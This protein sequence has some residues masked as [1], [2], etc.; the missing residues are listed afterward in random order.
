MRKVL[1]IALLSAFLAACNN[2]A[3]PPPPP[4]PPTPTTITSFG[5]SPNPS[6]QNVGTLFNWTVAGTNLTCKVDV[7]NDGTFEYTIAPCTSASKQAHVYTG[8][9][10]FTAKLVVSGDD[11]T[12]ERTANITIIPPNV[13]P[14]ITTFR[15]VQGKSPFEVTFIFRIEDPDSIPMCTLDVD[16]DGKVDYEIQACGN[17]PEI[18]PGPARFFQGQITHTY[19]NLGPF[20]AT[21][22]TSDGYSSDNANVGMNVPVNKPPVIEVFEAVHASYIWDD[23]KVRFNWKV[24]D[25]NNDPLVCEFFDGEK[26]FTVPN[27]ELTD[28]MLRNFIKSG[29]KKG[30]LK[31]TDPSGASDQA[32]IDFLVL[33]LITNLLDGALYDAQVPG[34]VGK[35][36]PAHPSLIP[37]PEGSMRYVLDAVPDDAWVGFLKGL[38]GVITLEFG[39]IYLNKNLHL[40]GPGPDV[41]EVSA[42]GD[43]RHFIVLSGIHSGKTTSPQQ[44]N[45]YNPNPISVYMSGMRLFDGYAREYYFCDIYPWA[46]DYSGPVAPADTNGYDQ[47]EGGSI[48]IYNGDLYLDNMLFEFNTANG[49]GGAIA[50]MGYGYGTVVAVPSV[51]NNLEIT[52]STLQCNNALTPNTYGGVQAANPAVNGGNGNSGGGAIAM[53]GANLTL[54]NTQLK[55]NS[56]GNSY[57]LLAPNKG[58]PCGPK[59]RNNNL[60][61]NYYQSI[62]VG[63]GLLAVYSTVSL[64][65]TLIDEN[66]ADFAGGV[67]LLNSQL[68]TNGTRIDQNFASLG[69]GGV[70]M[71]YSRFTMNSGSISNNFSYGNGGG[72][73]LSDSSIC[74]MFNLLFCNNSSLAPIP[75]NGGPSNLFIQRSGNISNNQSDSDGGG[76][77]LE[78]NPFEVSR[79]ELQ[80][81]QLS[82]NNAGDDGGGLFVNEYSEALQNGGSILNNSTNSGDGGGVFVHNAVFTLSNGQIT[83]N[84]ANNNGGGIFTL[85][86]GTV[87]LPN[88]GPVRISSNT[89]SLGGGL[90]SNDNTF[91]N[92]TGNFGTA[93][94]NNNTATSDAATNNTNVVP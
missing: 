28:G 3:P 19:P 63:G 18:R 59:L 2:A 79:Y 84:T 58:S 40:L 53:V 38:K 50:N 48:L 81:G 31:A 11:G 68:S 30:T 72:V 60:R 66:S 90:F 49:F 57:N 65:N 51:T 86:G 16:S 22:F 64:D 27:C 43:F 14:K 1:A 42:E 7:N 67:A 45:P 88:S 91:A 17:A 93:V 83:G 76:V 74:A 33:Y 41:I 39:P 13:S 78:S 55:Y 23:L 46:C 94:I 5:G 35:I 75:A 62:G 9:G 10:T 26:S 29:P 24:T 12:A 89:A 80:G 87:N 69:A 77:Y 4:P 6:P 25:P 52:N 15:V 37:A 36:N 85:S 82:N 8:L 73:G 56:A 70:G 92:V 47:A 61:P 21:L 20:N 44:P 54:K 71:V 32:Q 34:S